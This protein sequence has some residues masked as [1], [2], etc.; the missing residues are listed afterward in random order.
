MTEFELRQGLGQDIE[1]PREIEDRLSQACAQAREGR[2]PIEKRRRPMRAVRTALAA[3]VV[4]AALCAGA[5]AV[6]MVNHSGALQAF[7]GNESYPST[8]YTEYYDEFGNFYITSMNN[9]RVP[10]DDEQAEALVG[11]YLS[12]E[13]YVWQVGEYTMTIESY[14]LDENT[15]TAKVSY[16]LYRPGGVQGLIYDD[17]TGFLSADGSGIGIPQFR[18]TVNDSKSL[19]D[20]EFCPMHGDE[21]VDLTRSTADTLYIM[22]PLAMTG[23]KAADGLQV[24]IHD[25]SRID[26]TS[27]AP[28]PDTLVDTLDLPGLESLPAITFLN[29]ETGKPAAILSAIGILV[30]NGYLEPGDFVRD[31]TITYANG[32]IYLVRDNANNVQNYDYAY[33][34][35]GSSC[36]QGGTRFVFNRLVDPE[37]V[38]SVTI[39][40]QTYAVR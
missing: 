38:A 23:W 4:G 32:S 19:L 35:S 8:E 16:S 17:S 22:A 14:L 6:Y 34:S 5:G 11:A 20:G 29:P 39:D 3:A 21:R 37:Q 33:S 10:V 28:I 12:D 13:G 36:N 9:E 2:R 7:F 24:Q 27:M 30:D 15:G 31:I 26:Y 25:L 1:L 40:G 18:V